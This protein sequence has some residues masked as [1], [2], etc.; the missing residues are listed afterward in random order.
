MAHKFSDLSW[1][2]PGGRKKVV[3]IGKGFAHLHEATT[4]KVLL[5]KHV[6]GWKMTDFLLVVEPEEIL[7]FDVP[8]R[9]ENVPLV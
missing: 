5:G 9:P 4:E 6:Y 8:V 1:H 7:G 3:V 2:G